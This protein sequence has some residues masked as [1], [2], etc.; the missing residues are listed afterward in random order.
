MR[1]LDCTRFLPVNDFRPAP[2]AA[3]R[4]YVIEG[5]SSFVSP[6]RGDVS[7][8]GSGE[9]NLTRTHAFFY[10]FLE[11]KEDFSRARE[12]M[13]SRQRIFMKKKVTK[14]RKKSTPRPSPVDA[15]KG[16][17]ATLPKPG[18]TP[19][20]MQILS[21]PNPAGYVPTLV[22]VRYVTHLVRSGSRKKA[23]K[24][25]G[26]HECTPSYWKACNPGYDSWQKTVMQFYCNDLFEIALIQA[27]RAV[28]RGDRNM[29]MAILRMQT[30]MMKAKTIKSVKDDD[31]VIDEKELAEAKGRL[32]RNSA[33]VKRYGLD[34]QSRS[35]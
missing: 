33:I 29:I 35:A 24:A 11:K 19:N 6:G 5:I 4:S 16:G 23:C 31:A 28:E 3:L 1:Y 27:G 34:G 20:E 14:K 12:R 30:E 15:A 21:F 17:V 26:I 13:I 10:F 25:A 22:Q 9:R 18:L 32:R 7:P 8:E 2:D